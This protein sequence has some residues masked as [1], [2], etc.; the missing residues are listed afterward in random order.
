[1]KSLLALVIIFVVLSGYAEDQAATNNIKSYQYT[2]PEKTKEGG[3]TASLNSVNLDTNLI[4]ELFD[5]IGDNGYKN[6]HSVLLVKN[7]KLV[8]EAYF[9]GQDS[10]GQY[11]AFTLDTPHEMTSA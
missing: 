9:P 5:R 1:M 4:K 2:V 3:E 10:K 8:V 6:I 7:G 11:E